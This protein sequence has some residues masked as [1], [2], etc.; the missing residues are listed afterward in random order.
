[1]AAAQ[2]YLHGMWKACEAIGALRNSSDSLVAVWQSLSGQEAVWAGMAAYYG[3]FYS[4]WPEVPRVA[5]GIKK[6]V[7]RLK[8]LGNAI[9]PQ[10]A[11]E[12]VEAIAR[13][14]RGED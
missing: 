11:Y 2:S 10:V 5:T 3:P 1:M 12:I 8:G 7:D 13:I 4:E 6:R 9:V 14:E